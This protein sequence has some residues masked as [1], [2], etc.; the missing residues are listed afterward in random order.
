MLRLLLVALSN[1][2]PASAYHLRGSRELYAHDDDDDDGDLGPPLRALPRGRHAPHHL[3]ERA[4]ARHADPPLPGGAASP[5][6]S[7]R[8]RRPTP[9]TARLVC[10]SGMVEGGA[11]LTDAVVPAVSAWTLLLMRSAEILQWE[12]VFDGRQE[13]QDLAC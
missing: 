8:R 12:G 7:T 11:S 4:P 1:A 9:A 3:L 2:L 13:E 6:P 5:R 10:F